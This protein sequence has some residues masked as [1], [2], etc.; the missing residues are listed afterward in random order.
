MPPRIVRVT[1]DL[2][3]P[4]VKVLEYG[5]LIKGKLTEDQ[6]SELVELEEVLMEFS[7]FASAEDINDE[8]R[9]EL[10]GKKQR[11]EELKNLEGDHLSWTEQD[12]S[13]LNSLL[14]MM[15][16]DWIPVYVENIP[17]ELLVKMLDPNLTVHI[18]GQPVTTISEEPEPIPVAATPAPVS[19]N[20]AL[21]SEVI[22][23]IAVK[24]AMSANKDKPWVATKVNDG[25]HGLVYVSKDSPQGQQSLA[26]VVYAWPVKYLKDD[27]E[28]VNLAL[29]A[30]FGDKLDWV[31]TDPGKFS[32]WVVTF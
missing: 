13:T 8:K 27:W 28:P 5:Q 14:I 22:S 2:K 10:M 1:I 9:K 21:V 11:A 30:D 31:R 6:A 4:Y 26:G 7:D 20:V 32:H 16:T 12:V 24:P 29:K 3:D 18:T 17:Q 23:R 15:R 19:D 25:Y